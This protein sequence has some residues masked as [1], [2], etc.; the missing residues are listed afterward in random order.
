MDNLIENMDSIPNTIQTMPHKID[1]MLQNICNIIDKYTEHIKDADYI[2]IM[3]NVKN[4]FE[5]N[6]INKCKCNCEMYV[7]EYCGA[8][9][10]EFMKCK[11]YYRYLEKYPILKHFLILYDSTISIDSEFKFIREIV[12]NKEELTIYSR[13]YYMSFLRFIY[14]YMN[15]VSDYH[16]NILSIISL[17]FIMTHFYILK[18]IHP[19]FC[20]DKLEN[21]LYDI[22]Y[23]EEKYE[24][25]LENYGESIDII[26]HWLNFVDHK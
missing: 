2:E 12:D 17:N 20:G 3:N 4:I 7:H 10:H 5:L 9:I 23:N 24:E 15:T 13:S 22:L 26:V 25:I 19:L 21:S 11:N 8:T 16:K 1:I 14:F 18:E 6:L